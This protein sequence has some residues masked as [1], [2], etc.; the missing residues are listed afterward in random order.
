M[1]KDNFIS[2]KNYYGSVKF[3]QEQEVFYGKIE[4]IKDLVTFEA[5]DAKAIIPSF[6]EAVDDYIESCK[7]LNKKPDISFKGSFNVRISPDLHKKLSMYSI[8]NQDTINNVV[9]SAL[10]AFLDHH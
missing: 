3:D 8:S 1:N 10:K 2:Y 6:H 5:S 7:Y 4:F 9:K